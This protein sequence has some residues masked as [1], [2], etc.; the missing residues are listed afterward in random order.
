MNMNKATRKSEDGRM[1]T[2]MRRE[3]FT[4]CLARST[5]PSGMAASVSV[6]GIVYFLYSTLHIRRR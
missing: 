1:A 6:P 5:G 3:D 4:F 2:V